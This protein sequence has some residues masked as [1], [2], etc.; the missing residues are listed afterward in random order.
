MQMEWVLGAPQAS[1]SQVGKHQDKTIELTVSG[2]IH[3]D[4]EAILTGSAREPAQGMPP[5][6]YS[7]SIN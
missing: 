1:R 5:E 3:L 7:C 6:A 2:G 4:G